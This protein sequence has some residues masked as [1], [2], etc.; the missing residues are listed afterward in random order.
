MFRGEVRV[1]VRLAEPPQQ[2]CDQGLHL[3]FLARVTD[4]TIAREGPAELENQATGS[5]I[6]ELP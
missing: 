4:P 1:S 6:E 3:F 5:K 2:R